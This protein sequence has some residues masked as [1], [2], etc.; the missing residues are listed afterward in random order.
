MEAIAAFLASLD[1]A[2][3]LHL[4]A[5]Y[6]QYRYTL[7]PT[8]PSVLRG[9]AEVARRHLSYV[10]LGNIGS[11]PSNTLCRECAAVLVRRRGY[12][13]DTSGL[14][15]SRCARCGRPAPIERG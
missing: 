10:Y 7:P 6:P 15:S 9:L 5:Y 1:P 12:Q 2:I 4:S 13:V 14:D 8:S 11:E 3:P